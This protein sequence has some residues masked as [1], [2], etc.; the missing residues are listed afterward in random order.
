MHASCTIFCLIGLVA[1]YGKPI[2]DETQEN[3]DLRMPNVRPQT[4]DTYLCHPMKTDDT[5]YITGF[6]PHGESMIAHHILLYGCEEPG[7]ADESVWNCGEM[8]AK[9]KSNDYP[10][11]PVCKSGTKILYAWAMDAPKLNLPKDVGFKV[12]GDSAIKYLVVQVHYKNVEPFVAPNNQTDQSGLTL[13]TTTQ[14]QPKEAGVYL[15]GTGG[16]IPAHSTVFMETACLYHE[17]MALHPFAFRT[18]AHTLGQVVS[19]Y[20]VRDGEWT[21]IGRQSP[22]KPQMFYNVTR[23]GIRILPGDILAARCTMKNDL[24]HDVQ[25][26]STQKDEMCNFYMMYYVD[27]KTLPQEDSCWSMGPPSWSFEDFDQGFMNLEN[28]PKNIST[29]PNNNEVFH[30]TRKMVQQ[31]QND[32]DRLREDMEDRFLQLLEE[33]GT[34]GQGGYDAPEF[35]EYEGPGYQGYVEEGPGFKKVHEEWEEEY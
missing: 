31:T 23:P 28:L 33:I 7:A 5:K 21:E 25:I 10:S 4:P 12:G 26:G 2:E 32:V 15:L 19:G 24:D 27:G 17:D 3:V 6:V 11:A 18:H 16:N 8:E 22:Q 20:R 9:E 30:A 13:Q 35:R 29:D 14:Q 34:V 1:I